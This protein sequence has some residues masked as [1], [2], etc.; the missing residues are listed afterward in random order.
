MKF[1]AV[2]YILL[3][4]D[5]SLAT[6]VNVEPSDV[7]IKNERQ[8]RSGKVHQLWEKAQHVSILRL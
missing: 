2:S 6:A 1:Y 7:K 3:I 8:F 4:C 5:I